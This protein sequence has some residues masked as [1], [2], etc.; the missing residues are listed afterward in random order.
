VGGRELRAEIREKIFAQYALLVFTQRLDQA[1]STDTVMTLAHLETATAHQL[2]NFRDVLKKDLHDLA[3]KPGCGQRS[4]IF[5]CSL[6]AQAGYRLWE[7][8][9]N[10]LGVGDG[11][12]KAD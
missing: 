8:E 12:V 4:Q 3:A 1:E 6:V 11:S 2:R 5:T 9:Q 7:G 10:N